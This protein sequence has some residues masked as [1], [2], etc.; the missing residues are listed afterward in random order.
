MISLWSLKRL[1]LIDYVDLDIQGIIIS[2]L[3][4]FEDFDADSIVLMFLNMMTPSF[5]NFSSLG[6]L[7]GSEFSIVIRSKYR[8]HPQ[9]DSIE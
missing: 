9:S 1:S 7:R 5:F 6:R 3:I 2:V 4:F 8:V